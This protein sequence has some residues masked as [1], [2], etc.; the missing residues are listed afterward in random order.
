M[1]QQ[2]HS[3]VYIP[4]KKNTYLKRYVHPNVHSSIFLQ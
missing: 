3:W 4:E 2:F 1:T